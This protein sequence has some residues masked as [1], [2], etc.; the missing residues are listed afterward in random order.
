[1]ASLLILGAGGHGKV[2]AETAMLTRQW[3]RIAFLDNNNNLNN[4]MG[5]PI[6]G[7]FETYV[8]HV[9]SYSHAIVALG[10]NITR[11]IWMAKLE[12]AGFEIPVII[13]PSSIISRFCEI[14]S[15]SVV[16]AGVVVNA[17]TSI[18]NG[19]I[20]NTSSTIDHDCIIGKGV[21]ISPGVNVAGTVSIKDFSWLGIG[22]KIAN[23]VTIGSSVIVAAGA[24]VISDI[25][26]N[27][28]VA[29]VP[30]KIKKY[31]GDEQ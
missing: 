11:L 26:D 18:A 19:C 20:L 5:I 4:L 16:L 22:S 1:M 9:K 29:G 17:N 10:N 13:H 7:C 6:I 2:V 27:V 30:A 25:P 23:N 14:E 21:H 3:D 12:K 15:G 31:V 24:V 28:M 8:D